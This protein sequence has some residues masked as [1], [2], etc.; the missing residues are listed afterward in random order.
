MRTLLRV[1]KT[2]LRVLFFSPI[3]WLI[4]LVFAIQ[5]GV[6]YST[7]FSSRFLSQELGYGVNSAT[8][9]LYSGYGGL[10]TKLLEYLYLYIPLLTMGLMSRELSS[11]SIKLLYSSPVS[12]IQIIIGKYFSALVFGLILCFAFVIPFLHTYFNV[13]EADIPLMLTAAF[14]VYLSIAAYAAIGLFMSTIT[15][16]QVV[17]VVGTFAILSVLNFIGGVGQ[18]YDFVRDITYWLSIK[19]RSKEFVFGMIATKDILYFALVI[20]MFLGLSIIKLQGERLKLSK[21]N[22]FMR[23]ATIVVISLALGYLSS[24]PKFIKYLDVTATKMNTLTVESQDILKQFDGDMTI[25]TYANVLNDEF[26]RGSPRNRIADIEKFEKYIRFKPEIKMEYVYYYGWTDESRILDDYKDTVISVKEIYE[27]HCRKGYLQ[28]KNCP[29]VEEIQKM[30]DIITENGHFVRVISSK[31]KKAKLRI[32]KDN[33]V[34]PHEAQITTALKTMLVEETPFIGFVTGHNERGC[35]DYGE[36]GY[37]SFSVN[38]SYRYSLVNGGFRVKEITL[39]ETVPA[40][41]NNIVIADARSEF[42][43]EQH[44]NLDEY[45]ARGGNLFILGEPKRQHLM[46]PILSKLGLQLADGILVTPTDINLDDVVATKINSE[47]ASRVTERFGRYGKADYTIFT[48]S[49]CAV[50]VVDSTKG[51]TITEVLSTPDKGSWIEKETTNFIDEKS[52]VNPAIGEVEKSNAVMLYLTRNVNNKEQRIFVV[53]DAD[54]ISTLELSTDHPGYRSY[55][56]VIITEVF[57][58]LSYEEFPVEAYR[59]RPLDDKYITSPKSVT[60]VKVVTIGVLPGL[61]LIFG[62]VLLIRRKRR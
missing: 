39:D 41:I 42:S 6:E 30:D 8:S 38:N 5:V 13:H 9:E 17:A 20:F 55:N 46:N 19:G 54:C 32:Y 21:L 3:A 60:M 43:E 48:P 44:K 31:G 7:I 45:I 40:E 14:G 1:M 34:D 56:N 58:N 61:I 15:K 11:G 49:A 59:V 57:R 26:W 16:Y 53:G 51:F 27:E 52:T 10:M 23:Y 35:M 47:G 37:G 28:Y 29:P 22:S 2:E 18:E 24:R 4:L 25:T 62:V 50:E 12:N 33:Y 36:K